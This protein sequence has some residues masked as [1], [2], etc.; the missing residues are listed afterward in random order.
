[1]L[2]IFFW[3]VLSLLPLALLA[4]NEDKILKKSIKNL[5]LLPEANEPQRQMLYSALPLAQ[6]NP[7]ILEFDEVNEDFVRYTLKIIRCEADWSPSRLQNTEFLDDYNEFYI[8][9]YMQSFNTKMPYLRYQFALPKLKLSGNYLVQVYE[10]D[11]ETDLAFQK[12]FFIYEEKTVIT[13]ANGNVAGVAQFLTQQR[14]DMTVTYGAL[15]AQNPHQ[16]FKMVIRQN[17]RWDN[18]IYNIKP[19]GID[20]A[21]QKLIYNNPLSEQ[22]FEAGNEFRMVDLTN[23][24]LLSFR[25]DSVAS[26][27]NYF[28]AFVEKDVI[29]NGWVYD[30]R[31][32]D[33]NGRFMVGARNMRDAQIQGDYML[34]H[35]YLKSP[36]ELSQEVYL[37]G[38][39]SNWEI[40][41]DFKMSYKA[42]KQAYEVAVFLKQGIYNYLYAF[43]GESKADTQTIEGSFWQTRNEYDVLLY[44]RPFGARSD[45]LVGY[46]RQAE[47]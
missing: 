24:D 1:M 3:L 20:L 35:F 34:V 23:L 28:E 47:E 15:N 9:D 44:Y 46:R 41:E 26:Q 30:R 21:Q 2:K 18:A 42:P 37:F 16:Q 40:R 33:M 43:A 11:P 19:M 39:L 22:T 29:R 8:T 14:L 5:K 7:L 6:E 32:N 36:Q 45:L 17:N 25:V 4:E 31:Y 12:R 13:A 27:P 10:S 38:E